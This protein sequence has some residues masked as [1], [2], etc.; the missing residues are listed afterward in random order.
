MGILEAR[1]TAERVWVGGDVWEAQLCVG[2]DDGLGRLP[3]ERQPA[4]ACRCGF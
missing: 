2:T 1:E 4:F 3:Q